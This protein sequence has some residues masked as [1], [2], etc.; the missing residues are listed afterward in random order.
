F[1]LTISVWA[2]ISSFAFGAD[3]ADGIGI[4][5]R[6]AERVVEVGDLRKM[7]PLP[8]AS[9]DELG[10]LTRHF[11]QLVEGLRALAE[12]AETVAGGDLSVST[13]LR[14]DLAEAFGGMLQGLRAL[15]QQSRET[16]VQVA[17]AATEIYSASQEQEAA[18]TQ[19]SAAI[20][21]VARTMDSLATSAG[22]ISD[23][24]GTVLTDAERTR[25]TTEQMAARI[26]ELNGHAGRIGDLLEVIREVADRSDLLALNGSLE[27]T[28]AGES[29][30]GFG[31][32]AGEMRRLA[33]R[34]TATVESVRKLIG[35]VRAS[36]SATVMATDE[37]RKL[38][39]STT[40]TARRITLVTQQ[41]R[42]ATEQ[43]SASVREIAD[44]IAQ[45][46]TATTQTRVSAEELKAQA[47]RLE[48][49]LRRFRV[50]EAKSA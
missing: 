2:P 3:I 42:T 41:Q 26:T 30:R 46:A 31:L 32:V 23:S 4:L 21:E 14:G 13:E 20:T 40:E 11:N 18:A 22:H 24:A 33:E 12:Q 19:Q 5:T 50:G 37:S 38:A 16:S 15:V 47:D 35:D 43:V 9:E 44:V 27:A 8:V 7:D 39:E 1:I 45:T 49:L 36:G 34:V 10:G 28:R 29:G 6:A 25:V 17:S 48:E